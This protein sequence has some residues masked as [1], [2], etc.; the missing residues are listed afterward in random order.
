MSNK[1]YCTLKWVISLGFTSVF[2]PLK[3]GKTRWKNIRYL[4]SCFAYKNYYDYAKFFCFFELRFIEILFCG[5]K[6]GE[7]HYLCKEFLAYEN[8]IYSLI[9]KFY[10]FE[11]YVKTYVVSNLKKIQAWNIISNVML[12]TYFAKNYASFLLK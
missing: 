11:I 3:G 6:I 12:I 9:K 7:K 1:S 10:I 5:Q 8:K 4:Y 2:S